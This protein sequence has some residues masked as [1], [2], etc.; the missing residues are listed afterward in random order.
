MRQDIDRMTNAKDRYRSKVDRTPHHVI[1]L[2]REQRRRLASIPRYDRYIAEAAGD[3]SLQAFWRNLKRQALEDA[4]RIS[5]RLT[6]EALRCPS[7]GN[8]SASARQSVIPEEVE[9]A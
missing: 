1:A 2:H 3:L 5:D 8:T 4:Q 9:H 7:Y 6:R